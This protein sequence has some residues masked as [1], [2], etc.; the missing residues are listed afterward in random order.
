[1]EPKYWII[2]IV[3]VLI[4]LVFLRRR[5]SFSCPDCNNNQRDYY[6]IDEDVQTIMTHGRITKSGRTDKR[7]NT[8][9]GSRTIMTYGIECSNCGCTYIF[10]EGDIQILEPKEF[11]KNINEK[12]WLYY[13]YCHSLELGNHFRQL[14]KD[15]RELIR[16]ED[17][18]KKYKFNSKEEILKVFTLIEELKQNPEEPGFIKKIR[19]QNPELGDAW[20]KWNNDMDNTL[21]LAKNNFIKI[22]K[23]D[24]AREIDELIKKYESKGDNMHQEIP[25][26]KEL[27]NLLVGILNKV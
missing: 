12:K 1:M 9:Y 6:V 7:Y 8:Q 11:F 5:I 22:G 17:L 10:K 19:N 18:A 15:R 24:K 26:S 25:K 14:E 23:L 3:F 4:V 20:S 21:E 27:V 2:I 13:L 16:N